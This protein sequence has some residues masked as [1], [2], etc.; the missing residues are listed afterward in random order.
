MCMCVC[1]SHFEGCPEYH[2]RHGPE[3]IWVIDMGAM[4]P[5]L[6]IEGD[7][8]SS[9]RPI[10]PV[11]E[12]WKKLLS[13]IVKQGIL[14]VLAP[15]RLQF[16]E[17]LPADLEQRRH[18]YEE[19][20]RIAGKHGFSIFW[21]ICTRSNP[22]G[23]DAFCD[24][25]QTIASSRRKGCLRVLT[26]NRQY[27]VQAK[28]E[29]HTIISLEWEYIPTNL[30]KPA[31]A[32]APSGVAS[33]SGVAPMERMEEIMKM[34][35]LTPPARMK[36]IDKPF[37]HYE[38]CDDLDVTV[39]SVNDLDVTVGSANGTHRWC[40]WMRTLAADIISCAHTEE[41]S[42]SG[43][44]MACVASCST[45]TCA[46]N[47]NQA[48]APHSKESAGGDPD[49]SAQGTN[50]EFRE[51]RN[52]DMVSEGIRYLVDN[53]H[54]HGE[55]IAAIVEAGNPQQL[56]ARLCFHSTLE[57]FL[58]LLKVGGQQAEDR[59]EVTIERAI[60]VLIARE[61]N[62]GTWTN[63]KYAVAKTMYHLAEFK[64]DDAFQTATISKLANI[65]A[66]V[67]TMEAAIG[68]RSRRRACGDTESLQRMTE[69]VVRNAI[70]KPAQ[71]NGGVEGLPR[72]DGPRIGATESVK[73]PRKMYISVPLII[74]TGIM[75]RLK[76][77]N[78]TYADICEGDSC[79]IDK[80][81]GFQYLAG[82]TA[83]RVYTLLN[84]DNQEDPV[85]NALF[86][87]DRRHQEVPNLVRR[88]LTT[89][90]TA[91]RRIDAKAMAWCFIADYSQGELRRMTGKKY[92][93]KPPESVVGR[94]RSV[95]SSILLVSITTLKGVKGSGNSYQDQLGAPLDNNL[96]YEV[97]Q[98]IEFI[99]KF[100][101][102]TA[103]TKSDA[104]FPR[105]SMQPILTPL[106]TE[107]VAV[108]LRKTCLSSYL[109][110]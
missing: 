15:L 56:W 75:G 17:I 91:R 47:K 43:D 96:I 34:V 77:D 72:S 53:G 7:S 10:P 11:R 73:M 41:W 12:D 2:T 95:P 76:D 60:A 55:A 38:S 74:A 13:I 49:A 6:I 89:A 106:L 37:S 9:K 66:D 61:A 103:K 64:G 21:H 70:N 25:L 90:F 14:V 86:A 97:R 88:L 24:G 26:A 27:A 105:D 93:D 46:A 102:N 45:F 48:I 58:R 94:T 18:A 42:G 39:D 40:P 51:A 80:S 30:V 16:T 4:L 29:G 32:A 28:N 23:A 82:G 63:H 68:T 1:Q 59:R 19:L 101:P 85:M 8:S 109:V 98:L 54:F 22:T 52:A 87:Y 62:A 33:C 108:L 92:G 5:D 69:I 3:C 57:S 65:W 110:I 104:I 78:G 44:L 99:A 36:E 71:S 35:P 79:S 84:S 20:L 50:K 100:D 107:D 81:V 83:A 31:A 67:D